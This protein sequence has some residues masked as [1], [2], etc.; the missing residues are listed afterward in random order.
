MNTD[1]QYPFVV[2]TGYTVKNGEELIPEATQR[3]IAKEQAKEI[4]LLLWRAIRATATPEQLK[5][6]NAYGSLSVHLEE[7]E[8]YET[9]EIFTA[10]SEAEKAL[11]G[12]A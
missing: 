11:T 12:E 8:R 7:F 5:L 1:L 3:A 9:E 4:E 10:T 6:L 2:R